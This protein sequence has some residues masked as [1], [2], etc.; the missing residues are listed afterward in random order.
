[1][2]LDTVHDLPA[3]LWKMGGAGRGETN[4][5]AE[6]SYKNA[7]RTIPACLILATALDTFTKGQREIV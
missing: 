6:R 3:R 4:M 5:V 7:I 2:N 1:M